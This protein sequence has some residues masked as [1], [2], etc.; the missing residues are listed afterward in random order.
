MVLP[1]DAPKIVGWSISEDVTSENPGICFQRWHLWVDLGDGK[2]RRAFV[3]QL[4]PCPQD[5]DVDI[6]VMT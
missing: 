3:S 4:V 6:V 5:A 2:L 1:D